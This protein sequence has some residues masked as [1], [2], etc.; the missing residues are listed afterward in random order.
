M[1]SLPFQDV[2]EFSDI[3]TPEYGDSLRKPELRYTNMSTIKMDRACSHR[4]EEQCERFARSAAFLGISWRSNTSIQRAQVVQSTVA[5]IDQIMIEAERAIQ[6]KMA[7]LRVGVDEFGKVV[8]EDS[9]DRWYRNI[10]DLTGKY[11]VTRDATA[12]SLT[13]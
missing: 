10:E 13:L 12:I 2:E 6:E 1:D 7:Q 5:Q 8:W 3:N 4:I 9:D 11:W